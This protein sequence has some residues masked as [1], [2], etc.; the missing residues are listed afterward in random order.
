MQKNENRLCPLPYEEVLEDIINPF[1]A[2]PGPCTG[3]L[4]L[5]TMLI[6]DCVRVS[7]QLIHY[8]LSSR[9]VWPD[10]SSVLQTIMDMYYSCHLVTVWR[11]LTAATLWSGRVWA[12]CWV[13]SQNSGGVDVLA[14][15][16]TVRLYMIT[17]PYKTRRATT[18]QCM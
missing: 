13:D 3:I 5:I 18:Q 6:P 11:V 16:K 7:L 8:M 10:A 1:H 9:Q 14:W 2:F 4:I 15:I 17:M 12:F